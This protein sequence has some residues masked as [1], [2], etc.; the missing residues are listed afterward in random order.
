MPAPPMAA[1][2][3]VNVWLKEIDE[4]KAK[5]QMSKTAR[6]AHT[7]PLAQL[8]ST[9]TKHDENTLRSLKVTRRVREESLTNAGFL[10]SGNSCVQGSWGHP[11]AGSGIC[12]D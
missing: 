11:D 9:D 7:V 3:A 6:S 10:D 12:N 8:P 1:S 2:K 5:N 4:G